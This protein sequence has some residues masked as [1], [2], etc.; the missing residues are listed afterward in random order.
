MKVS[1]GLTDNDVI[2]GNTFDKYNSKNPIV[3]R[4]MKGFHSSLNELVVAAHERLTK[5]T[6]QSEPPAPEPDE[7]PEQGGTTTETPEAAQETK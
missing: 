7:T 1:G 4:I 2:V 3:R 5:W 6:M